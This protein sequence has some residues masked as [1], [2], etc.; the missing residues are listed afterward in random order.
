MLRSLP[1]D[2]PSQLVLLRWSARQSPRITTYMGSGDCASDMRFGAANP[3][4]CEFSEPLYREIAKSNVFSGVVA[5]ANSGRLDVTGNG[6]PAVITGQVVSGNFF[7]VLGVKAA[8]GR[9]FE[10]SDDSPA[11]PSMAVLNYGY[12]QSAYGGSRDAIGR[13]IVLNSVPFTIVGVAE[14]RFNG[15]TPGSDY[16]VWLPL[17][18]APRINDPV[19]WRNRQDDITQWWLTLVARLNSQTPLS[20][21]QAAASAI[22]R[23]QM[24]H[25]AIAIFQAGGIP[26]PHGPGPGAGPGRQMMAV[27]GPPPSGATP[28]RS[29]AP[30]RPTAGPMTIRPAPAPNA[31]GQAANAHTPSQG[32]AHAAVRPAPNAAAPEQNTLSTPDDQPAMTLEPAQSGL[33]GYRTQYANPL[34]VL[35]V[36]VGIILLI[37]CANVAGLMLAR[38]AARRKE[39]AVRL[40]LGAARKRIVRQ[41]LTESILLSA[42]AGGLGIVFAYWSAHTIVSFVSHNQPRPLAV[43]S[44]IDLRVLAFTLSIS[45]LT[46]IF[47]GI[48]PAFRSV[49]VDLTPVLKEGEGGSSGS[50]HARRLSA[51][52]LLVVGQ[53]ALAV[54]V[55]VGAGLLVRTLQNLRSVDVGFDSHNLVI[56]DLDAAHAGY[57]DAQLASLYR[58]LQGRLAETPGV[59]S[60]SYSE[61]PLLGGGLLRTI[62]HWPGTPEDRMSEANILAVGPDFFGTMHIPL[63]EGRGLNSTD[64]ALV[65]N[66]SPVSPP[67]A[68]VPVIVDQAFVAKYLGHE[69]PLGKQFGQSPAGE[70]GPAN[71]GWVIVGV[72]RDAKYS[73]MREDIF[74]TMYVPQSGFGFGTVTYELRTAADPQAL[75]PSIRKTVAQLNP[76]LPLFNIRTESEQ[77]DRLLFQERLVAR[78]STFFGVLALLLACIGLYGML[79]YEVARRT[80]EIGIRMALGAQFGDVL[81]LVVKQ[82]LALALLGAALGIGV[83]LGLTRYLTAMLYNV[84]A[85]DPSTMIAVA[86]LL[87]IVALAACYIPARRAALVD[88]VEALRHE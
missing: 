68:A 80:R 50:G 7:R 62:F 14:Q 12:W 37:A 10:A 3:S 85:N 69:N 54:V 51:G 81:R 72:V 82:G 58:D 75:L 4:G 9:V 39:M 25:G 86:A 1:V 79:S 46:G 18:D 66:A 27:G 67:S 44:A 70:F 32:P 53:V 47:F 45:L 34:Y 31:S 22:F 88:P 6:T 23:N 63:L 21:A 83:A 2:K 84:R 61:M 78:L 87:A 24:L 17:A 65:A 77:I 56:F 38:S 29:P 11:A 73:D 19:R 42:F 43:Q 16:A 41:L 33:T 55:L 52:S 13:T 71:P 8:A 15:L 60:A 40:A 74:A 5:F 36:A 28:A 76:N 20:Q 59:K 26:G 57:Q 48:A 30:A 35:M 49:R 64:Y